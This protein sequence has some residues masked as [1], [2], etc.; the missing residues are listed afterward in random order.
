MGYKQ[1]L[2]KDIGT[3][4][5]AHLWDSMSWT[6]NKNFLTSY[7]DFNPINTKVLHNTVQCCASVKKSN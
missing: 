4:T 3:S 1:I 5:V 6:F 2:W 7:S